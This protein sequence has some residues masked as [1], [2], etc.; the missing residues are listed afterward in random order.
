MVV[1]MASSLIKKLEL[2]HF[3]DQNLLKFQRNVKETFDVLS[4][5]PIVDG[6]LH[7]DISIT[8]TGI[9]LSHKLDRDFIGYIVTK[10]DTL[11]NFA[12]VDENDKGLFLNIKSSANLIADVWVF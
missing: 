8:T 4:T 11:G 7:K 1:F 6:I 12:T 9:S 3:K 10:Q 5:I 2:Q